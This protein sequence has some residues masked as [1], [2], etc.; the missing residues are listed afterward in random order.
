MEMVGSEA[1]VKLQGE[2]RGIE[3]VDVE[4]VPSNE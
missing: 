4:N 3:S 1:I 2:M